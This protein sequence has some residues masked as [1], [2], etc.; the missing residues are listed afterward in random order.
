MHALTSGGSA[1][2]VLTQGHT[3]VYAQELALAFYAG[4]EA[5]GGRARWLQPV[6]LHTPPQPLF[7]SGTNTITKPRKPP[8]NIIGCSQSLFS[9]HKR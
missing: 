7:N 3:S 2:V 6:V 4:P 5:R 9:H 8:Y 1:Y